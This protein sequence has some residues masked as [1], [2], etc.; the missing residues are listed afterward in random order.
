[1][2]SE[3]YGMTQ[4]QIDN[5]AQRCHSYEA[6]DYTLK[7][8]KQTSKYRNSVR[9][10]VR[11]MLRALEHDG[12]KLAGRSPTPVAPVSP[13]PAGEPFQ[14]RVKPWMLACFGEEISNDKLERCDRFIEEAL[15]L[16]QSIGYSP[17]RARALVDYVFNREIGE[18]HQEVGGVM[19]TLAALCLASDLDMAKAGEDE[20]ARIW[21]KVEKIR[22]KQAAKPTGSALPVAV[23]PDATGKCGELVTLGFVHPTFVKERERGYDEIF[24]TVRVPENWE[25]VVTRSQAEELLA[26]ERV[27]NETQAEIIDKLHSIITKLEADNAALTA[28]VKELEETKSVIAADKAMFLDLAAKN[29]DLVVALEA[30]HAAALEALKNMMGCY[31]TPLSRRRF[32]PDDLMKEA[33]RTA[34]TLLDGVLDG[35]FDTKS[36]LKTDVEAAFRSGWEKGK[37]E[38]ALNCEREAGELSGLVDDVAYH[39]KRR[40]KSIR[41]TP[42]KKE[43]L[44]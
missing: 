40:A 19:V 30:K 9:K 8:G 20:L 10:S 43:A 22:A 25:P 7:W 3:P 16:V 2:A 36:V 4:E 23:S 37:N 31:D 21:T 42:L 38:A 29:G 28:R 13:E 44:Q 33:I 35:E 5:I 18:P 32:P 12:F 34:R 15:E 6:D 27:R 11:S 24:R 17:D 26:A 1:M 14:N 41:D 39:L